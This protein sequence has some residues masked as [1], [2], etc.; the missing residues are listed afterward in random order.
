ME[1][2][3]KANTLTLP[4]KLLYKAPTC[5]SKDRLWFDKEPH[6]WDFDFSLERALVASCIRENRCPT[7]AEWAHF[8]LSGAVVAALRGKYI[9]PPE[10]E[11]WDWAANLE[12][13]SWEVLWE[14]D[15]KHPEVL[16][17]TFKASLFRDFLPREHYAPP[18]H[19]YSMSNFQQCWINFYPDTLMD[20]IGNIRLARLKEGCKIFLTL[21]EEI[22]ASIDL[23]A[24]HTP[25]MLEIATSRFRKK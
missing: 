20:S 17:K 8:C 13:F 6:N 21:P 10:P 18:D 15:Q 4:G 7:I 1:C 12:H 11:P 2:L 14:A 19:P 24:K 5:W 9:V 25:T 3:T 23:V 16:D 22:R